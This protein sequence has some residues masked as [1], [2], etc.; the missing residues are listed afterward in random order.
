MGNQPSVV[1]KRALLPSFTMYF[2]LEIYYIAAISVL[3][4]CGP[5]Y[6]LKFYNIY[7]LNKYFIMR[8]CNRIQQSILVRFREIRNNNVN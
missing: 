2:M 7:D 4:V 5:Y 6:L 3:I 8:S 1:A